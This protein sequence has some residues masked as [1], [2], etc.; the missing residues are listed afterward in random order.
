MLRSLA[1]ALLFLGLAST[2][3]AADEPSRVFELRTYH[4]ADAK[5]VDLHKRFRDQT[6]E[7][8]KKHGAELVGFWTPLDEKDGKSK[9]LIYLVAYPNREAAAATWKAFGEDPAWQKAKAESEINGR[10]VEKVDSV[11][12]EPTDYSAMK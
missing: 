12:L 1:A 3:T 5:L 7:L 2:V 4:T 6:C 8:L 9:T 11:Y 10:L